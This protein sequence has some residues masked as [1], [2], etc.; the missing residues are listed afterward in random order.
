MQWS[1]EGPE[2]RDR[3]DKP[4]KYRR[5]AEPQETLHRRRVTPGK[6]DSRVKPLAPGGI[7]ETD[8]K[9]ED[10]GHDPIF[11]RPPAT[12]ED[13][14]CEGKCEKREECIPDGAVKSGLHDIGGSTV[15]IGVKGRLE[16][17]PD[18]I[19]EHGE[20]RQ[21]DLRGMKR[22]SKRAFLRPPAH[23]SLTTPGSRLSSGAT[24]W[25]GHQSG[26]SPWNAIS[27][28]QP[29]GCR[30]TPTPRPARP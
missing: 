6:S 30:A 15:V 25:F 11:P 8:Q 3:C 10:A 12:P 2:D 23:C 21:A 27:R 19:E 1:P 16:E 9:K 29:G 14:R 20:D 26:L 5:G 4:L 22:P 17:L 13:Q 24:G 18:A 7:A 28:R